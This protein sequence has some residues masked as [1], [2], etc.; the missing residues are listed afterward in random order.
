MPN[1]ADTTQPTDLCPNQSG[2]TLERTDTIDGQK[3]KILVCGCPIKHKMC[4]PELTYDKVYDY[5]W[6][7]VC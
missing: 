7:I 4:Q 2:Y 1:S 6:P 5:I 3:F